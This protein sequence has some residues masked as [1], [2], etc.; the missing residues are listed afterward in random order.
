MQLHRVTIPTYH[1][2]HLLSLYLL[3]LPG[4]DIYM[5][6][7][8]PSLTHSSIHLS[9]HHPLIL[10]HSLTQPFYPS[11]IHTL[12]LSITQSLTQSLAL[13]LSITCSITHSIHLF[14]T[15]SLAT[16]CPFPDLEYL[17]LQAVSRKTRDRILSCP[18]QTSSCDLRWNL[19]R[20]KRSKAEKYERAE[21]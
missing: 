20:A 10:T 1:P 15:H 6:Y 12:T 9:I 18:S 7:I 13:S 19:L 8:Y 21:G 3:L 14:V 4:L 16:I 2:T 11:L 17:L 5:V